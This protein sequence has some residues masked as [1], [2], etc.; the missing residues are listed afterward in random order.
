MTLTKAPVLTW[1]DFSLEFIV[2]CDASQGAIG[3]GQYTYVL[4]FQDLFT[5]WTELRPLRL[6]SEK[7]VAKAFEEL[8]L[9]CWG[10][11]DYLLIDIGKELNNKDLKRSLKI[12]G[13][14]KVTTSPY[15]SQINP[16]ERSNSTL[17]TIIATFVKTDHRS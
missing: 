16:V 13:V 15:H 2:Q 14:T 17:K 8:V 7:N 6:A 12:Y 4:V 10:S 3:K 9:F 1:P 11:P 5:R